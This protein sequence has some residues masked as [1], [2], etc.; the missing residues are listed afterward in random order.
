MKA[1]WNDDNTVTVTL[2]PFE[3]G[4]E[5]PESST[6]ASHMIDNSGGFIVM[7]TPHTGEVFKLD[8]KLIRVIPK[9]QRKPKEAEG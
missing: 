3:P 6:G 5:Y 2:G 9:K 8:C 7:Q 1:V 4:K